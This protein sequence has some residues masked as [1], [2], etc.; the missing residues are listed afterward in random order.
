MLVGRFGHVRR[1]AS[2]LGTSREALTTGATSSSGRMRMTL[3]QDQ[4]HL[5]PEQMCLV[6]PAVLHD[7]G[8]HEPRHLALRTRLT[9]V[10][11]VKVPA[12]GQRIGA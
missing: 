9:S 6:Q 3:F 8:E 5:V 10:T 7:V 4:V 11:N 1:K 2:A 12:T